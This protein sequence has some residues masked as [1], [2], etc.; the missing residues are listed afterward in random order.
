MNNNSH[1]GYIRMPWKRPE[2][3]PLGQVW[4]RFKG[5]ER[6]GRPTH[7]YQIRDMDASIAKKCLD[8]MQEVFLRDE[9]LCKILNINDDPVSIATIR[10]NW[11]TYVSQN[12]SLA[13]FTEVDG[14]PD[15]LVG[16]NIIVIKSLDDED[17]DL[18]QVQGESWKKLLK[19]LITA[20]SLVDVFKHYGV[21]KF[22]TS[23]GLTVLPNHR[24]QNI[25]A[26]LFAAREPL[27]NALGIEATAT[28][29]TALESQALAA[30]CGYEVLA[31][32]EYKDM[33]KYGIDLTGCLTPVAK[34]MGTKF[35]KN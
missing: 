28:V 22:L 16:F 27:C 5:R 3:V 23:S 24:G 30:K 21:D 31:E 18:D 13:C 1:H 20:E 19:T 14:Q 6:E 33:M 34:L 10:T 12:V 29:F 35:K 2:N 25:G 32:L 11:E 26:R 9:P 15:E 8:F 7:M 4:S 17:E